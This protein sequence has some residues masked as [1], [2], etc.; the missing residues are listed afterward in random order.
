MHKALIA[1]IITVFVLSSAIGNLCSDVHAG[2][3]CSPAAISACDDNADT[4]S[5]NAPADPDHDDHSDGGHC[6]DC[7]GCSC[8][9]SAVNNLISLKYSPLVVS[10]SCIEPVSQFPEVFLPKFVPPESLS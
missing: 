9:R 6:D 2:S 5:D 1:L 10:L 3:V 7:C 8:N 4:P